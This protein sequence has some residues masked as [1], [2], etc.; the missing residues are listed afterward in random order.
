MKSL[1]NRLANLHVTKEM[2][3]PDGRVVNNSRMVTVTA[4]AIILNARDHSDKPV[5]LDRAAGITATLPA[6]TGSGARFEIIVGTTVTSNTSVVK[7]ANAT[8]VFAG[9]V[10]QS[11]DT[12]NTVVVYDTAAT[13]DTITM[14]GSTTGGLIGDRI[15]LVDMK[16]GF[17]A[18][19][20]FSSATGTEATPLSATV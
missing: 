18:L 12:G 4:S 8:D 16:P 9:R 5:V 10:I 6:S 7:V 19:E 13:D 11:A 17:W 20:M 15:V 1:W 14:N 2:Q 3:L